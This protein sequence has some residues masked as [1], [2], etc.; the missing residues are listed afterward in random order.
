MFAL[1]IDLSSQVVEHFLPQTNYYVKNKLQIL[2]LS[3]EQLPRVESG[4]FMQYSS[5]SGQSPPLP[6]NLMTHSVSD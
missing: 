4:Y 1:E 6:I 3:L 2:M 5:V